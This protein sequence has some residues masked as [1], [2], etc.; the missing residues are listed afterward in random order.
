LKGVGTTM[1][2][3]FNPTKIT[4]SGYCTFKSGIDREG[5]SIRNKFIYSPLI[6]FPLNKSVICTDEHGHFTRNID[7]RTEI[8]FTLYDSKFTSQSIGAITYTST[9]DLIYPRTESDIGGQDIS[10]E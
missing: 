5:N 2:Q 10:I 8:K 7:F 4:S 3:L 1:K 9:T 6:S